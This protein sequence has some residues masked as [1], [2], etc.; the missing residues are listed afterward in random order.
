MARN[1]LNTEETLEIILR[2]GSDL[3]WENKQRRSGQCETVE[4]KVNFRGF[5]SPLGEESFGELGLIRPPSP[6]VMAW[7]LRDDE[8]RFFYS[9]SRII[10]SNPFN[11]RRL[12]LYKYNRVKS[13]EKL[14]SSI[15]SVG[16]HQV[17]ICCRFA[18]WTLIGS[19][20][21]GWQFVT[22]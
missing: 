9:F 5:V 2:D 1:F 20:H 14:C 6:H 22:C 8:L 15:L 21:L 13:T 16:K 4:V 18:L 11:L 17:I 10:A 12:R 7:R 3:D 19:R